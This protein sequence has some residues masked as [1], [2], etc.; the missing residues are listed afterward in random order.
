MTTSND[1][2]EK[3]AASNEA[4]DCVVDVFLR[5]APKI[6]ADETLQNKLLMDFDHVASETA[7]GTQ[8]ITA[9][10]RSGFGET[11]G[12]A[13]G[14]FRLA[15]MGAIAGLGAIGFLAGIATAGSAPNFQLEDEFLFYMSDAS[16][17]AGSEEIEPWA[18][19]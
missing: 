10:S 12:R 9:H 11:I 5:S 2:F 16:A 17:F 4:D 8:A 18:A 19:D 14:R 6:R 15:T 7:M 1:E 13:I 3:D